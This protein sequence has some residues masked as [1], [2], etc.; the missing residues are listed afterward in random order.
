MNVLVPINH[1]KDI[2]SLAESGADEFYV[3][4]YEAS[5]D[6]NNKFFYDLN[7]ISSKSF[8]SIYKGCGHLTPTV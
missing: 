1:S 7:R 8:M 4:F 6:S 3:G 5:W 2:K